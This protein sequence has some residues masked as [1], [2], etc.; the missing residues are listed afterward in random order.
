[1]YEVMEDFERAKEEEREKEKAFKSEET[2]L[3]L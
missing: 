1:M 2:N 3:N